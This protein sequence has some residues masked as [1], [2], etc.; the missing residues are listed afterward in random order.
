MNINLKNIGIEK[1]QHYESIITS[2][3]EKN[4]KNAAPIGIVCLKKDEIQCR[5]FKGTQTLENIL[6][7][8]KFIVNITLNPLYFTLAT[9]GNLPEEYYEKDSLNI[10]NVDAYFKCE[11]IGDIKIA[12]KDNDPVRKTEAGIF[13]SKVTEIIINNPCVKA[14]N[15]GFYNVIEALVNFTRVN[16][17]DE[18]QK[19]FY[20]NRLKELS[21][22][23]NKVGSNEEKKAIKIITEEYDKKLK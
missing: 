21:R 19:T 20:L 6:L 8:K 5:I 18:Q 23:V 22:V 2:I 17:V 15:R 1:G 13:K 16:I 12:I 3:N 10:K 9:I 11:V 4:E 7:E 14:P